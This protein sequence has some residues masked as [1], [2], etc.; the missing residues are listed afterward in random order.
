MQEIYKNK[1]LEKKIT[2]AEAAKTRKAEKSVHIT[3][4]NCNNC[5]NFDKFI[6]TYKANVNNYVICSRLI[7]LKSVRRISYDFCLSKE[8]LFI[9][10]PIKWQLLHNY[11]YRV[12]CISHACSNVTWHVHV[13]FK[14]YFHNLLKIEN[15]TYNYFFTTKCNDISIL[16][17]IFSCDYS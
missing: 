2:K 1:S 15:I 7:H 13:L 10:L 17:T 6:Q 12:I 14:E 9:N 5:N 16:F 3:K 11:A 8:Y 4:F